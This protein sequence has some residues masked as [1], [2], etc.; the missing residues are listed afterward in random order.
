MLLFVSGIVLAQDTGTV[1][2]KVDSTTTPV[3]LESGYSLAELFF[4]TGFLGTTVTIKYGDADDTTNCVITQDMDGAVL[5]ITNI[6]APCRVVLTPTQVWTGRS[7]ELTTNAAD[8][9]NVAIWKAIEL[10][11]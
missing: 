5:Q 8:S 11:K 10:V 2:F 1:M 6:S 4:P 3:L 9:G 7:F